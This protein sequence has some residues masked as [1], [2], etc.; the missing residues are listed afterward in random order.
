MSSS[1]STSRNFQFNHTQQ[2]QQQQQSSPS[3][4]NGNNN[5][6]TI[7]LQSRSGFQ[8]YFSSSVGTAASSTSNNN[9][10]NKKDSLNLI[11]QL[12]SSVQSH[13]QQPFHLQGP[14]VG[15]TGRNN[16]NV[17]Y[18]NKT[19]ASVTTATIPQGSVITSGSGPGGKKGQS[20]T[21]SSQ[22]NKALVTNGVHKTNNNVQ[23]GKTGIVKSHPR[24]L[25]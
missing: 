2:Q 5:T 9:K 25:V 10:S 18:N 13:Q 20:V 6:K 11:N 1:Q 23:K 8:P 22:N 24:V 15:T 3:K 4:A 14:H 12:N 17:L 21:I 7:H 16:N 19:G